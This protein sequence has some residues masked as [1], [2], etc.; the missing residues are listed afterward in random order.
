MKCRCKHNLGKHAVSKSDKEAEGFLYNVLI[1]EGRAALAWRM[2]TAGHPRHVGRLW[3][4]FRARA[5]GRQ[6]SQA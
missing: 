5:A 1:V 3:W 2:A 4:T 6:L